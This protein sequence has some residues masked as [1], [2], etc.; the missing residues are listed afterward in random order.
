M[1]IVFCHR[2]DFAT[3]LEE[4]LKAMDW[5]VRQGWA[6]YWGTSE[7]PVDRITKAIEICEKRGWVKPVVEQCE[8][9]LL[10]RDNMEKKLRRLFKE[11]KYGTTIW[12]ALASGLLSGKYN[13]GNIPEGSR[14]DT[15]PAAG[16]LLQKYF[17]KDKDETCAKMRKL[18]ELA[19]QLGTS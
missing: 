7:W 13:D 1:D 14:L 19:D 2:P 10:V 5:V 15:N 9:N 3:P 12:S 16:F 11:T 17:T 18:K 8:Y 4:T 6:F